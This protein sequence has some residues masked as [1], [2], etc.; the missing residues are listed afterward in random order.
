VIC[1]GQTV[2]FTAIGT[3]G[4]T[5]PSY[6]W[7]VNGVNV[8]TNSNTFSS[9]TLQN[10]NVV[11]VIITSNE[12]C[13]SPATATSNSITMQVTASLVPTISIAA[14]PT[15]A[16][17]AGTNVTFTAT[18]TN[19]GA[20]PSYQWQVNG[21]NVGT[22][23]N[24]FS[25]STL[26][27]SSTVTCILTSSDPC[28]NP[29]TVTS[30]TITMTV[31]PVLTPSVTIA[32][33]PTGTICAGT[34][35]TFTAT[36]TNGGTTPAYQWQVN[37]ANVGTN[38][39]TFSSATLQNGDV[40]TVI[41]TSNANCVSPAT[42]TSNSITMQVNPVLTPTV[43]ITSN[44]NG[45]IC[46]GTNVTFT[47]TPTNG[48]PA[49]AY[50][51]QVNGA[52]VGTNSNTFSST[53]LQNGDVVTVILT[54][55]APC[56]NP[57]TAS[58]SIT[59]TVNPVLVPTVSITA[60]PSG[61][62]C[63]GTSVTFT[64]TITNGGTSPVYQWQVNGVNS[65][66]NSSTFTSSALQ[67]GDIVNVTLTSNALCA[68]PV[69]V[70]S[71]N[72]VMQVNPLV[73]PTVNITANPA[74]I[75]CPGT[76]ITYTATITNGGT[77]PSYQWLV[78]GNPSGTNQSTFSSSTLQDGD[79]VSVVLTSDAVCLNT[80]T[81]T[82]NV[83][84]VTWYP[85]VSLAVSPDVTICEGEKVTIS[86]TPSAGNPASYSIVWQPGGMGGGSVTVGP[87]T[88]TT[89]T[90]T[91][92]DLCGS[93]ATGSVTVTVTPKPVA[94]FTFTPTVPD[95]T[96]QPT[97]FSDAST[98]AASWYWNFGDNNTSFTRDPSFEFTQG[99]VYNIRLIVTSADGCTDTAMAT[100][101]IEELYTLYVP[102]A[103]SPNDDGFNPIWRPYGTGL[104]NYQLTVFNRWGQIVFESP[105]IDH[106]W[107]GLLGSGEKAPQGVYD[108]RID[109]MFDNEDTQ[110]LIGKLTLLR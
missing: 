26:T 23:S 28:A 54:S 20:N 52:N 60:N 89:Y 41:L 57:L 48:G 68:S 40:V 109:V 105:K 96:N 16:I 107:N 45:P 25:S 73:T 82:S 6:Q 90:A 85:P 37:G 35:V 67:N 69:N 4:G 70:T 1:P 62:I 12:P 99:G 38:S 72:I 63:A 27:N 81:A 92:T 5:N 84:G 94:A 2:T 66:T 61:P 83:I 78:N 106:G 31:N 19:G 49:P 9:S 36:P 102:S 59:I 32:A 93:T 64:A 87:N 42:A 110:T 15:G 98:N 104:K 33:N 86:A 17:C 44:P 88:T 34:S 43:S 100:I 53:T 11:T 13:V 22:N 91:V 103:F 47:A 46:A 101:V 75:V 24:T 80:P 76:S 14:N 7:Q 18:I 8:G 79:A 39:N 77:N 51:W 29:V 55:N 21:A 10:G 56:A 97:L 30:N 50:Q 58:N 3:N 71:N 74:G 65:G 95:L 108:Y